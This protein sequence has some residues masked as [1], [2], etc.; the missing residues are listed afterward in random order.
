MTL[1]SLSEHTRSSA[2]N[3]SLLL[4]LQT[5]RSPIERDLMNEIKQNGG[6]EHVLQNEALMK[7]LIEKSETLKD[8]RVLPKDAQA[9]LLKEI[10]RDMGRSFADMIKENED[11]FSRKFKAQETALKE[12]MEMITRREGNRVIGAI[13]A[14]PHD[15]IQDPV[16]HTLLHVPFVDPIVWI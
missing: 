14:G 10:S 9:T 5:L 12:E 4:L 15:R 7:E 13:L 8:T 2:S 3:I 16:S 1:F 11:L 6:P